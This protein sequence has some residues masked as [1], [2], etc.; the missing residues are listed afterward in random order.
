MALVATA[1]LTLTRA[2]G[3]QPMRTG[4][5]TNPYLR[6]QPGH[7]YPSASADGQCAWSGVAKC[8]G[9]EAASAEV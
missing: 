1:L 9:S 6:Q 7:T 8:T 4:G 2:G 5:C 3:A